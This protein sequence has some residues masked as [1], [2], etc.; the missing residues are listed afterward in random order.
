VATPALFYDAAELALKTHAYP[1]EEINDYLGTFPARA[2][3]VRE[4]LGYYDLRAFVPAVTASTLLMV[5]PPGALLD[6]AALTPLVTA[7]GARATVYES[8]QSSYKDGLY[9]ERW[10]AAQCGVE[11]VQAIL[12]EHWRD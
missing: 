4:T 6:R 12:P 8:A 1:L 9:A 7:L 10:M 2:Q 11:D 5:G 3:A